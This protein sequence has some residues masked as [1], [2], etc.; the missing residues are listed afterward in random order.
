M[1]VLYL[2]GSISCGINTQAVNALLPSSRSY[3][4]PEM[5]SCMEEVKNHQTKPD[6]AKNKSE[7]LQVI[8]S[9]L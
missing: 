9:P 4:C 3:S 8:T 6:L 7:G 5:K 1:Q 2:H